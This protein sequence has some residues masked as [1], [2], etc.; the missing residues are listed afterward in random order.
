MIT[1]VHNPKIQLVHSLLG[2]PKER[3]E[4]KAFVAEG[5][6]LVEEVA[7]PNVG[8]LLDTFH[9]N[10]EEKDM[11]APLPAIRDILA[12]VHLSETNRDVLGTGHWPSTAFLAK[13]DG[14]GYRGYCSMEFDSPGDPYKGTTE[15]IADTLRYLS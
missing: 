7:H 13:L 10:I 15:L 12:H 5:V 4:A 6:R 11:L 14:M 8:V 3:R 1:S 9:L 2:R